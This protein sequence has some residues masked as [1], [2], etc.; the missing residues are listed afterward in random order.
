MWTW[1]PHFEICFAASLARTNFRSPSLYACSE[2]DPAL[3]DQ[4]EDYYLYG[5]MLV[6]C[7][8]EE[9]GGHAVMMAGGSLGKKLLKLFDPRP[10][11]LKQI[12][13]NPGANN[14][15]NDIGDVTDESPVPGIYNPQMDG[16]DVGNQCVEQ[17]CDKGWT[18]AGRVLMGSDVQ[19]PWGSC[20]EEGKNSEVGQS[21]S[22]L[23]LRDLTSFGKPWQLNMYRKIW[24]SRDKEDKNKNIK[25]G[26][27]ELHSQRHMYQLQRFLVSQLPRS[28]TCFPS[29]RGCAQRMIAY[30]RAAVTG[31]G[32]VD[33]YEKK[34]AAYA[35]KYGRVRFAM[36][37]NYPTF[38]RTELTGVA[39]TMGFLK[40]QVEL[41]EQND[42]YLVLVMHDATDHFGYQY[43]FK[44]VARH[45][46]YSEVL[47][48]SRTIAVFAGHLHPQG[49]FKRALSSFVLDSRH[50]TDE[51]DSNINVK[52]AWGDEI[53]VML[54]WAAEYV[55]E[56]SGVRRAG[57]E[58]EYPELGRN[59]RVRHDSA[60]LSMDCAHRDLDGTFDLVLTTGLLAADF[61]GCLVSQSPW[62]YDRFISEK[63]V[64]GLKSAP[65]LLSVV[66]WGPPWPDGRRQS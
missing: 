18:E 22:S 36:L 51:K 44:Q 35:V 10:L 3:G 46:Y 20:V 30:I 5:R 39:S 45:D 41:A 29:P 66:L 2:A 19:L 38:R 61:V 26:V 14:A 28:A 42:E 9:A 25:M 62:H 48:G 55:R 52:N 24:E 6:R 17:G 40:K 63:P 64:S 37:H 27:S 31:C 21:L 4:V 65:R 12:S 15:D 47:T 7:F 11:Q 34:S 50:R 16:K 59:L 23:Q 49:G 53:P 43:W 13:Y 57:W 56:P 33:H 8:L 58:M 60:G 54:N 32:H 1:F